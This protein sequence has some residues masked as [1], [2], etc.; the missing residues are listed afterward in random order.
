MGNES[1][2]ER[3]ESGSFDRSMKN[4]SET[5]KKLLDKLRLQVTDLELRWSEDRGAA[6]LLKGRLMPWERFQKADEILRT[7]LAEYGP[8]VGPED[9]LENHRFTGFGPAKE[10]GYRARAYQIFKNLPVYGATVV[11][12]ADEERGVYRVQSSFWREVKVTAEQKLR[13]EDLRKQLRERLLQDPDAPKF[14]EAWRKEGEPDPWAARHFPLVSRPTLY[15]NRVPGGFHPAY[16]VWAYQ[17]VQ[18]LGVDGKPRRTI[19]RVE[20]MVDAA[21]G[22]VLWQEPA[23]EGLAYTD[24]LGDG[25]STLQ[26]ASNNYLVRPLRIVQEDSGDYFLINRTHTP[27]I[28]THD[29]GG[30]ETGLVNKLKTD[31]DISQDA[32]GHWNQTSSSCTAANRRDSQQP[33]ADGHFHAEEAWDF[34]HN[35]GWD[36]FDNGGW[37]A[38]CPVRVV[39]HIGMDANAYFKKYSEWDADLGGDKYYGYVAFYDGSCVGGSLSFDFIAGDPV[40]FGHEYQHAITYFGAAKPAGDPGHLYGSMWL[41]TIRE[42]FS[43][44]FGCL[45]RGLWTG[46]PFWRNGVLRSGQPFRRI[47]YPRSANTSSGD[48]YCDHYDDRD[49]TKDKYF[50]STLLSHVAYLVGQGGVHQRTSRDAEFIP[51]VS[52]GRTRTAEIFLHA[53]TQYYATIPTNLAAPTLI[54]AAR[55]LLDAAEAVSGSKRSCEYVMMRR[56]LYAVGLHPYDSAYSKQTY[57]GEA[58]MLPWTIAWQFSQPYLGFPPLWYKS[59]DLF[60]N[61]NG[62]PEYD[63]V[64]GQENKLFAR[65]RNIGDQDLNNVRVRYLYLRCGTNLPADMTQWL[66]CQDIAGVDCILNISLLPAGD[67]NFTDPNNPPADQAVNW[68]LDPAMVTED[69]DHFCVR[70]VI[71]FPSNPPPNHDNDCPNYVQSN[72]QHRSI[73]ITGTVKAVNVGVYWDQNC[74]EAVTSIDW[75][76]LEPGESKN[77]TIYL[78]NEGN[79]P[80]NLSLNMSNWNPAEAKNYMSLSWTYSGENLQPDQALSAILILSVEQN[81]TDITTF[82]FDIIIMGEG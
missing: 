69:V 80:I 73:S 60:I 72:I 37:G 34:Y 81:V 29:A 20:L 23:K 76:M 51:V 82:N 54:E 25:L 67:M 42:G 26:D 33:E 2:R 10:G 22:E 18:W 65:V 24:T 68:Y 38:H 3:E 45:R 4:I 14:E 36:G 1:I 62:S 74:T 19:D 7:V 12:F 57:G 64:I 52:V 17:P 30:T 27:H 44:A 77:V 11:A 41:G 47:E 13:E 48:W 61:N 59:P 21:T 56:A 71:E 70:A 9:F 43:D 49:S 5:Q 39:A 55:N 15:L 46:P 6:S 50:H 16:H 28:I 8:L 63:A 58:C 66:P 79:T 35:L 75:G 53:L 40:I 31:S 78:K 32:D